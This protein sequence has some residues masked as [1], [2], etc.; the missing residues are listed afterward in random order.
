[1]NR[2]RFVYRGGALVAL[3][4]GC[5]GMLS[6]HGERPELPLGHQLGHLHNGAGILWAKTD[7]PGRLVLEQSG[8][9][10]A[11]DV[12]AETDFTGK[13]PLNGDYRFWFEGAAGAKSQSVSGTWQPPGAGAVRIVWGGDVC[14]Q[15]YGIGHGGYRTFES[16]LACKPD[17]FIHSGDS[18][19]ADHPLE[20]ETLSGDGTVWKNDLRLGK[21]KVAETLREFRDNFAYNLKDTHYQR[22][23]SSVPMIPQWDD[24]ETR[25]NW[26]PGQIIE[27]DRYEERRANV[28]ADRALRAFEEYMPTRGR[29]YRVHRVSEAVEVFMLDL[30]THRSPNRGAEGYSKLLGSEQVYWL[31]N[32]LKSSTATW[33]VVAS[34]MPLGVVIPDGETRFEGVANG[35]PGQPLG[36]ELEIAALLQQIRD[37]KNVVWVS[38]DVHYAAAH[39]YHPDRARF[40]EFS[41]F[42]E[43]VA[44]PLHAG[45]YGPSPL[46]EHAV[47]PKGVVQG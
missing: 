30:R 40:R 37:V 1:M 8:N 9:R 18:I 26:W 7:R 46:G 25:N 2:R 5:A 43:F 21:E 11:V 22:F 13:L 29:M 17:V 24:H 28:L 3:S 23:V 10:T 19:Y 16:M 15:G 32:A 45:T 39:H 31:V 4:S 36:R 44:G 41:P 38:A 6:R 20:A 42:W 14:G 33:K 12:T 34:S 47:W 35:D 27:D